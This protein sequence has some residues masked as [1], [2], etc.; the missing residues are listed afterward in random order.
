M[1]YLAWRTSTLPSEV[2]RTQ[3]VTPYE[4]AFFRVKYLHCILFSISFEFGK[5]HKIYR[6]LT[7]IS[8]LASIS[9]TKDANGD[10]P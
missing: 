1:E 5:I 10:L 8:L 6:K 4:T 2:L 9:T 3:P 7:P